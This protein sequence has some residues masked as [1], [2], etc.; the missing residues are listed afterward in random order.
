MNEY[1]DILPKQTLYNGTWYA[2]KLE[3]KWAVFFT[4]A[5][6]EFI[7]QPGSFPKND[8]GNYKPDFYL[9]SFDLFVEVKRNSESGISEIFSRCLEAIHWGGKI[10]QILIL[11]DVPMGHSPDGGIWHFPIIYWAATDVKWGWWFFFDESFADEHDNLHSGIWGKISRHP[12]PAPPFHLNRLII[13]SGKSINAISDFEL[14][15]CWPFYKKASDNIDE[16]I[17]MQ[18]SYNKHTF[19]ALEKANKAWFGKYGQPDTK[20]VF[21]EEEN[22]N[23]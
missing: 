4:C 8:G 11:T 10:K 15:K 22:E 19:K 21:E 18:E 20:S 1:T 5:E 16:D 2:S 17:L 6:I 13:N 14:R 7:Y 9:P 23:D 3:A 12:Y